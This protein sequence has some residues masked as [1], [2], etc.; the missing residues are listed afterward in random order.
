MA[1][2]SRIQ[3]TD[4]EGGG[5][6][7][8]AEESERIV[9]YALEL[10]ARSASAD[11]FDEVCFMLTN[12]LRILL[13][14]ERCFLVTHFGGRSELVAATQQPLLDGKSRLQER[15]TELARNLR[16]LEKPL[17]L[18][19]ENG[20]VSPGA[21]DLPPDLASAL[22]SYA[23]A[24]KSRYLCCIPL[25]YNKYVIAHLLFEYFDEQA[26][27]RL[28]IMSLTKIAPILGE[29]L[30]G[31]WLLE[32]RPRI[33]QDI[34]PRQQTGRLASSLR[35]PGTLAATIVAVLLAAALLIPIGFT[36]GGEAVIAPTEKDYAF[37]RIGGLI[38]KVFVHGGSR[39]SKG[40]T[41]AVL[42]STDLDHQI[43][44]QE[45]QA[46]ILS[47]EIEF[48]RSKALEDPSRLAQS[49]LL[50]LKR[51]SAEEEL[52]YLKWQRRFLRISSPV[53]G[54]IMTKEVETLAGKRINAGEPFCE[55]AVPG[56]LDAD[57]YVPEDR[58]MR[59][60]KGQPVDLYLNNAPLT[61]YKLKVDDIAA[62]SEA[63]PR[64][65]NV[66]KV[67]ARFVNAPPEVRVGMKGLGKIHTGKL[68]V[69]SIIARR[70]V[71]RWNQFSLHFR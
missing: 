26:P 34:A 65:G 13:Q 54:V 41:L 9:A 24:S 36:V 21:E 52:Q 7:P 45:R 69:G 29:A 27:P 30:A 55:I 15:L 33:L 68:R 10:A 12:D 11:S 28:P 61:A 57:V 67:T 14:F 8:Q 44:S 19:N 38:D 43:A 4:R 46:A 70:I 1:S 71:A 35:R 23:E 16:G 5:E 66:F 60:R 42:D 37:C 32:N 17:A 48:A 20:L 49:R 47:K 18:A 2:V 50:E 39:I 22:D 63:Q 31:R 59:I 40:Q 6:V 64:L 56:A 51:K 53:D 58:V 3:T 25:S 62:K